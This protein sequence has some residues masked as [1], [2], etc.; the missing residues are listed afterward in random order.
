M[1]CAYTSCYII[2]DF[3]NLPRNVKD[4]TVIAVSAGLM[5]ILKL[6]K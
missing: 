3:A 4:T 6:E 5:H 1:F 2:A